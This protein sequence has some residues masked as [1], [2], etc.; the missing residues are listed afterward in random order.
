MGSKVASSGLGGGCNSLSGP[1][2][3]STA[4]SVVYERTGSLF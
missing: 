2:L 3:V 1:M 4:R